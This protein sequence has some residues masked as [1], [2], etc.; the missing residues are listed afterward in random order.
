MVIK[1]LRKYVPGS[2]ATVIF[3]QLLRDIIDSHRD[4]NLNPIQRIRKLWYNLFLIRIWRQF[5]VSHR[6]Y[7]LIDNFLSSNCLLFMYRDKRTQFSVM[8][9]TF[10]IN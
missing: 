8:Y 5:I 10:E 2:E 1:C 7:K 3:L 9:S 4:Q 6:N